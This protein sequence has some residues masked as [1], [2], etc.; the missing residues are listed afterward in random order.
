MTTL[1]MISCQRERTHTCSAVHKPQTAMQA[2]T[3]R[4]MPKRRP[5]AAPTGCRR[6]KKAKKTATAVLRSSG[7]RPTSLVKSAVY[8]SN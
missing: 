2:G 4:A 1:S 3:Y 5:S 6:T 7:R 8:V